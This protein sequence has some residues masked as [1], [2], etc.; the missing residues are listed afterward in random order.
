MILMTYLLVLLG[1]V[2]IGRQTVIW[3]PLEKSQ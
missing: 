2:L 3:V 1:G